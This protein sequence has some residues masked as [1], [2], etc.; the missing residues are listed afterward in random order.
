VSG[1]AVAG[2]RGGT[3]GKAGGATRAKAGAKAGNAR[4]AGAKAGNAR[5][6]G[7]K[8][9][10]TRA[11]ARAAGAKA[12]AAGVTR[13]NAGAAGGKAGVTRANARAAGATRGRARPAARGRTRATSARRAALIGFFLRTLTLRMLPPRMRRRALL[14]L[15]ACA[16]LAGGYQFWLRD[17]PLV[18]VEDVKVTGLTTKDAARVRAA[19]VS[20][21]HTMTTLHVQQSELEHAIS[22]YPVVRALEVQADFPHGLQIHVVEHRPAAIVGGLPVAGDGT[23]LRGLP[24]EGRLPSI[25]ARGGLGGARLSD[26]VALH[27][28]RVAGAAPAPLRGRL[29]RIDM[30]SEQGIVVEMRDG[31]ELIFGDST[32][33]RAK[34]IAAVRVLA[35]PKAE[36]ASYID[37]RL[38]GR[39]AAGG[40]PAA[41]LAP[42]APAGSADLAAPAATAPAAPAVDPATEQLAPPPT[43]G[44]P[45]TAPAGTAPTTQAAPPPVEPTPGATDS[46]GAG[47]VSPPPG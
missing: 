47:G 33:V 7:G 39:P 30:R 36:G 37:V 8:A 14:V 19:L 12:G 45:A 40:L 21:A 25:E 44:A 34:W 22:A 1:G 5:A 20:E 17:S 32:Q 6:A 3:R 43:A 13:A 38:P 31:P 9:G 46:T 27:A 24:V 23:I 28:A 16:V 11:T 15:A 10:V 2:G 35:D 26:P 42:V 4:A 18:A 41:T 29:Q